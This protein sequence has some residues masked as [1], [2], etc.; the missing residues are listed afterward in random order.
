MATSAKKP[1]PLYEFC[2]QL[3][4]V[5]EDVKWEN[6]LVF[7]VGGKMFAAFQLPEGE[8]IGLKVDPAAFPVVIQQSG[9]SPAPYLAKHSWVKIATRETLPAETLKDL[10]REAHALVAAKLPKKLR[11]SLGLP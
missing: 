8:P 3:P 4:G 11:A 10:L 1:D 7:S 9:I 2:R 6:D 5:T